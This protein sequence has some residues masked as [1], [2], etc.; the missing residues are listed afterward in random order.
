MVIVTWE[1]KNATTMVRYFKHLQF[2]VLENSLPSQY[3]SCSSALDDQALED[4]T[5]LRQVLLTV[6]YLP[7]GQLIGSQLF[8]DLLFVQQLLILNPLFLCLHS[9]D[10]DKQGL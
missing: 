9:T 7:I 8:R 4:I 2:L 6:Q 3:G 1:N 10:L 5:M